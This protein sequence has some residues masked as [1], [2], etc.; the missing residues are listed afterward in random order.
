VTK[1][2]CS[3]DPQGIFWLDCDCKKRNA[4]ELIE[5]FEALA[6]G[7]ITSKYIPAYHFESGLDK[8]LKNFL[9]MMDHWE[10]REPGK[11]ARHINKRIIEPVRE[12]A[13]VN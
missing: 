4:S 7:Q 2:D 13:S 8:T 3:V 10:W 5:V 6:G 11:P 9:P 1:A 12:Q